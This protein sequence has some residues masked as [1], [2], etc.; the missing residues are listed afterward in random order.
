M[1]DYS[2]E[3]LK[4]MSQEQI[5]E[6]QK[7]NCIF[8]KIVAGEIPSKK[9]YE[10]NNFIGVLDINPA[11]SGH[12]LLIPKTH[13]QIMPQMNPEAVGKMGIAVKKT[14]DKILKSLGVTGTTVFIANGGGAGQKAP[15]FMVHIIPRKDDDGLPL[16]P[17]LNDISDNDYAEARAKVMTG[18]GIRP[19][20]TAK[21]EEKPSEPEDDDNDDDT[22]L[23]AVSKYLN[24]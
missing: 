21:K 9:V 11:A 14:S 24:G 8:C 12:T 19:A 6:L 2:E 18:L 3:D 7:Q 17:T 22:D 15:H 13:V 5:Y 1:A 23:D 10:D 4:N 16:N 20:S